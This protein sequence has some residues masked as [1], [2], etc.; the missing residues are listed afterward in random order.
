M[1]GFIF[2]NF[3]IF[4]HFENN[5]FCH[6]PSHDNG[7]S[8]TYIKLSKEKNVECFYE[9][10]DSPL[11]QLGNAKFNAS[12]LVVLYMKSLPRPVQ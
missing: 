2:K 9:T 5:F 6:V 4:K 12:L 3:K 7:T 11:S 8:E 10:T 1:K